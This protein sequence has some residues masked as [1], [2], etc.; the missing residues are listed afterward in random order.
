VPNIIVIGASAGGV[1]PLREIASRL[2]AD[3]KVAIFIVMHVS[4]V[5]PS[6]LP[7]ILN[8]VAIGREEQAA[9][10]REMLTSKDAHKKRPMRLHE[11]KYN[12]GRVPTGG[13]SPCRRACQKRKSVGYLVL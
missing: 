11:R 7:Q 3:L 8:E 6:V 5:A 10:I 4:P 12:H 1:A 13:A 9:L 2:P